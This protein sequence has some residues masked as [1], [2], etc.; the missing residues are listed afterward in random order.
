MSCGDAVRAG[1]SRPLYSHAVALRESPPD[2]SKRER[3]YAPFIFLLITEISTIAGERVC[4]NVKYVNKKEI[5]VV[6]AILI[7]AAAVAVW[8]VLSADVSPS[9]STG[10]AP[11][12]PSAAQTEAVSTS[13]LGASILE[14]AQNPLQD[15]VPELAPAPN[16]IKD[17][18]KN[19]FE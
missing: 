3:D 15:K 7:I 14:K 9:P 17:A 6:G 1:L 11:A 19:P 10:Q 13:S 16:P 5:I 18:Y 2:I 8:Y 4:Y 12:A